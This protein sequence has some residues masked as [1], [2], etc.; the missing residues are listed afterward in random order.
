MT[1]ALPTELAADV[2]STAVVLQ[3]LPTVPGLEAL[4]NLVVVLAFV[5]LAG[6][7]VGSVAP[8]VPSGLLSLSGVVT[9]WFATGFSDPDLLVLAG[10]V[11]V[12][13][14]AMAAEW[15]SGAIS[16]KAGGASTRTT[17]AATVVGFVGLLWVGP[18]GFILGT[19]L[20]VF[21]L[22]YREND[23]AEASA[24]AAGV[25]M[26]GMLTSSLVQL[27]LTAGVLVVM[28]LVLVF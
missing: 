22:T 26:L 27:L 9:Y 28:V 3:L 1:P 24:R 7:V 23:D 10:L 20:T 13:V 15:L 21:G 16:A 6:G 8:V 2:H 18:V 19:A 25:T 17:V 12:S 5:L 11:F 4:P 14:V